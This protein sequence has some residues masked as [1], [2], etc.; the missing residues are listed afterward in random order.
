MVYDGLKTLGQGAIL[1]G[2]VLGAIVAFIIDKT[3]LARGDLRR[4]GRVLTF[5]GLIHA[6]KV[7]WNADGQVAL[8]YL[9]LAVVCVLFALSHRPARGRRW[10]AHRPAR[11]PR[12][13]PRAEPGA[14]VPAESPVGDGRSAS[15]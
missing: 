12:I 8:G 9:F 6:E 3:L 1:A 7:Q 4:A 14:G 15:A 5:V 13:S 10:R 11:A 2:L